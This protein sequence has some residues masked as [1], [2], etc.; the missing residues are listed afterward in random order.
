MLTASAVALALIP[1]TR[2]VAWIALLA[3]P[4]GF[5]HLRGRAA[6]FHAASAAFLMYMLVHGRPRFAFTVTD[7]LTIRAS[8]MLGMLGLAAALLADWNARHGSVSRT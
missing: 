1:A 7:Q 3:L 6:G 2:I 5:G 4:A 8:F